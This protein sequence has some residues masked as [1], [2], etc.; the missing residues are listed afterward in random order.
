MIA[1]V[2][3]TCRA[4]FRI[5]AE[6]DSGN[7]SVRRIWCV[8]YAPELRDAHRWAP[9][10]V[11][12][13]HVQFDRRGNLNGWECIAGM[14]G[15]FRR[16]LDEGASVVVKRDS[17]T[18]ILDYNALVTDGLGVGIHK[19]G[20]EPWD[21]FGAAYSLTR[22]GVDALAEG[23]AAKDFPKEHERRLGVPE[24]RAV[25]WILRDRWT[26]LPHSRCHFK[27]GGGGP[28]ESAVWTNSRNRW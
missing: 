18:M 27:L 8:A 17:D 13:W 19:T 5:A 28:I 16:L 1:E 4:H 23:V 22:A 9:P 7:P 12:V 26:V 24:D 25:S 2:C 15:V 21:A 3:F 10:G 11:E 20:Y 6:N 14:L